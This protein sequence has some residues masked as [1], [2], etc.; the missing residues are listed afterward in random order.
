MT[1]LYIKSRDQILLNQERSGL[2]TQVLNSVEPYGPTYI[3][4]FIQRKGYAGSHY[5]ENY[6]DSRSENIVEVQKDFTKVGY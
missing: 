2:P 5:H 4:N 3:Y 6:R 1:D